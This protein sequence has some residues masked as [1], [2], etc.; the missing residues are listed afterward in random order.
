M[1]PKKDRPKKDR[2]LAPK[3]LKFVAF[4]EGNQV[5]AAEKAGYKF[6]KAVA[7]AVFNRPQVRA[8]I[9]KKQAAFFD[10]LGKNEARGVKITRNDIINRLDRLSQKAETD[11]A[12]V[13]ALR[14]LKDIFGLSPRHDKDTNLFAG[15]STQELDHYARTGKLPEW[16][17]SGVGTSDGEAESTVPTGRA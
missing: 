9:K 13:M 2:P 5:K 11:S 10:K 15:W 8:A 14:E 17:R 3:E 7:S 12:R 16:V 1:P 6:P 4:Y